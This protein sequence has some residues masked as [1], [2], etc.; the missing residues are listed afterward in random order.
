LTAI[1]C[2]S[3]SGIF[4]CIPPF[5]AVLRPARYGVVVALAT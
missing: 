3:G 5:S 4:G 2:S 1:G